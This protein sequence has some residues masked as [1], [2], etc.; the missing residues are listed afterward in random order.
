M[1]DGEVVEDGE[2][3][4]AAELLQARR[5]L[6]GRHRSGASTSPASLYRYRGAKV[7]LLVSFSEYWKN[8]RLISLTALPTWLLRRRGSL[9]PWSWPRPHPSLLFYFR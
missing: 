4:L 5:L 8:F 1:L 2:Q 6:V 7:P 9:T 3:H